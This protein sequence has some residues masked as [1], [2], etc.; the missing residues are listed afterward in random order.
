MTTRNYAA[1][2]RDARGAIR[3]YSVVARD[4][5]DAE[6]RLRASSD[7]DRL[8]RPIHITLR[9]LNHGPGTRRLWEV[10]P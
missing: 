7:V 1:L 8:P 6:R 10:A 2:V 5:Y 9:V 4:R 3:V